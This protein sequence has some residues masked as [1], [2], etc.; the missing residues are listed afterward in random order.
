MYGCICES[1]III[2][3]YYWIYALVHT[4]LKSIGSTNTYFS[5][6]PFSILNFLMYLNERI[7]WLN[8]I[9]KY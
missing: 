6:F 2:C 3:N 1:L 7:Y 9:I 8:K 5:H 4:T